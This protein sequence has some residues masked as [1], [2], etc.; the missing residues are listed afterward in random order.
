MDAVFQYYKIRHIKTGRVSGMAMSPDE[1]KLT[2]M[3][4]DEIRKEMRDILKWSNIF[5][6]SKKQT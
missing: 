6:L 2:S 1:E 5:L 3:C 4:A